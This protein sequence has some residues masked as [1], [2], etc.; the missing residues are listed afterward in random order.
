MLIPLQA[1]DDVG[2]KREAAEKIAE[3]EDGPKL[4]ADYLR[5]LNDCGLTFNEEINKCYK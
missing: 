3:M 1:I 4:I 2:I 5:F